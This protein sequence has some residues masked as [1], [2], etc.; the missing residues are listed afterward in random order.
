MV[1]QQRSEKSTPPS[2]Q[3]EPPDPPEEMVE[4]PPTNSDVKDA[5]IINMDHVT[6]NTTKQLTYKVIRVMNHFIDHIIKHYNDKDT[7]VTETAQWYVKWKTIY[8]VIRSSR[9]S[10]IEVHRMLFDDYEIKDENINLYDTVMN[11]V[12]SIPHMKGCYDINETPTADKTNEFQF[13]LRLYRGNIDDANNTYS[14]IEEN[15]S[16]PSMYR[17]FTDSRS[18]STW[19]T[20]RTV[21]TPIPE[22]VDITKS[23]NS[24]DQSSQVTDETKNGQPGPKDPEPNKLFPS[25]PLSSSKLTK[26][27]KFTKNQ[28]LIKDELKNTCEQEIRQSMQGLTS[29]LTNLMIQQ[30]QMLR[31]LS[32]SYAQHGNVKN[33]SNEDF[34]NNP[35]NNFAEQLND[36]LPTRVPSSRSNIQSPTSPTPLRRHMRYNATPSPLANPSGHRP[37]FQRTSF[38]HRSGSLYFKYQGSDYELRDSQYAKNSAEL[39]EVNDK[40]DLVHFYEE[41]QSDAITYNI[42]LQQFDL[43]QPWQKYITETLPPTCI[44]DNL[45]IQENTIDAYNRMKNALYTKLSKSQIN[46]PEYKA[47]VKHG[48]IGKDGFEILYELMTHCHPKLMVASTKIRDT[49]PRPHIDDQESIYSYLEKLTT[50]LT[51]EQINGM[52]HNDDQILNIVMEEMR[53]DTRYQAAIDGISSELTIRDT[54]Q[55]MHGS[56]QFPENL[57]LYNLPSTIMSYYSKEEKMSLFPTDNSLSPVV[58]S[59]KPTAAVLTNNTTQNSE[60]NDL[61]QAILQITT[62]PKQAQVLLAR[63]GVDEQCEGCG[64]YGHNVFQTGCD[65]CAQFILIQR[66]LEKHPSHTKPI[67][68]KYKAHQQELMKER[69]KRK[70]KREPFKKDKSKS[71]YSFKSRKARIQRIHDALDHALL[72]P[73]ESSDEE[74]S[75]ASAGS[76]GEETDASQE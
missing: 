5:V 9:R 52:Q 56:S 8:P 36:E 71:S 14:P 65:R 66:Y 10:M 49:N 25:K 47:I 76:R 53:S 22:N 30:N 67:L 13:K 15:E 34:H 57:K 29:S 44:F 68:A 23:Q 28:Q 21:T 33:Q 20:N 39:R 18:I 69:K 24:D 27:V 12:M 46:D 31:N 73:S 41:M 60:S 7:A 63:E 62:D 6:I 54:F 38:A 64:L 40:T 11:L 26:K 55:R 16:L 48:S 74:E 42:F 19:Q 3:Q 4:T 59:L 72:P 75:Y 2:K 1:Q 32:Y 51:I 58:Q 17:P 43:L 70:E 37:T 35:H 50:W 45:T 61:A